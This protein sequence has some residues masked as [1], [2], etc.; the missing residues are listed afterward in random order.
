MR[1]FTRSTA[2]EGGASVDNAS[3]EKG[4][5]IFSKTGILAP[6]RKT[7]TSAT[8]VTRTIKASTQQL[9]RRYVLELIFQEKEL[10]PSKDGR[11]IP[12]GPH[13]DKPLIDERRGSAYI[14][15]TIRTSRYTIYDFIPKQLFF[16][17]SRLA[18]FYFLCVGVPQTIPGVSTTGNFTTI[19]PLLFFVFLTVVK[20]GYDDWKRH[21]L[22]KVENARSATVLRPTGHVDSRQDWRTGF[23]LRRTKDNKTVAVEEII[24][25]SEY[26]WHATQWK[27]LKVGDV[28][29]LSRDEDVP[30]D[31][32]LLYADGENSMAYIETMSLDGETNLKNKQVSKALQRCNTIQGIANCQAEFVVEDPNPDLYRFDGRVT[33]DG[34]TLPLTLNEV[35][36]R[37]CT[38]RNTTCAIGM[39]I[40]TGEECKLRR[41]ADRHPKAKKPA[42]EKIANRIVISLVVV[43]ISLS[44]GCSMGYLIWKNA[45]EHK[46]WY[47]RHLGVDFEDII[48]GFFIQFNNIIPLA[49]YVSLEIVKLGQMWFLNSDVEMYDKV[50]DTPAKCN[51]NTILENLGQIGYVFSDKTGTLTENVMKFR[52]MSIAGTTWLHEMDIVKEQEEQGL[53]QTKTKGKELNVMLE[54]TF[55]NDN[56]L[57]KTTTAVSVRS[58]NPRRSSSQWRSTGR[59][60]HVQPEVTT[61][62]LLEYIRLRPKAPFSRKAIQYL[63]AMALCHTCLPEIRDGE[64][65]FQAASPDELA[66][67]KAAQELGF[68]VVQRSSQSVTLRISRGDGTEL[69]RTYQILDLIEFSSKRKRM[70]II[71]RCPDERIWLIT[72]GADSVILPRLRMAQLAIQKA[73]EVRKSLEVEHEMQRRSEAR[74]PRNSFGGRPSLTIRRSIN[75]ARQSSVAGPSKRP[76]T[77]RSKSFEVGRMSLSA[78]EYHLRPQVTVRT[79]SYDVPYE[80]VVAASVS[81]KFA[82]LDDPSVCDEGAIFTRCFK[83]IDDFAT[84][85]LRTLL[86]A[87]RFLS[88]S[89]YNT[90]KKLYRDAETSL[91]DR[92]ERIETA[93]ELIEQTLDLIGATAI[94]DKLQKGVPETIERLRRANIKIWML[95][96]DKRETAINIAH[97]ARLC[98]PTSDIYILDATKGN[99]EGQIMDIVDELNIRAETMPTAIPNHTVVV[100]DGHTLAALDE[101]EA[102]G[103]A[104]ELFY[105]LIPTI[106]SVICCRA[107]PAQKAL[108]VTAIR[109]H[110][111]QPST[112]KKKGFLAYLVTPKRTP[113]LTLA[114]GDGANDLAMLSA[115]HVGVGIS[116]REGLQ[117]ARVADYAVSQFRFLSRLLLVHGRWNY[118]RTSKFIVATFWKEMFFYLPTELYQR[119][120]GYTG[121][122]LY[123]S[124]SLTVLNTLFTSLCVIVPGVWEQDLSAETLMAVPEL[125]VWGQRDG[126][127]N[128]RKYL[129]WMVAA[130]AQGVVV[131]W[132]CWGL[133][134][135]IAVKDN[136][137]FAVGNLVFTVA[138]VWT[139]LKLIIIDTHHKT[140]I[141]L[142]AFGITFAGWWIWQIFLASAYAPGV[143]PYAV[144][145]GFFSSFGPDPAWWVALFAAVGLL[146][147]VELGYKSTKRNLIIS[148]LWRLGWRKWMQWETWKGLLALGRGGGARGA[149]PM[150]AWDEA[151]GEGRNVDEWDVELWQALERE[152]TVRE[153]LKGMARVGHEGDGPEPEEKSKEEE[154]NEKNRV[155]GSSTMDSEGQHES[156]VVESLQISK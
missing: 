142:G 67:V 50:S 121:T 20:E 106:D 59:P 60:D 113:P 84:E 13:H 10:P 136:G 30:A 94:E 79:A 8:T 72:K 145:G 127:L 42:M 14:P 102:H 130:V 15:N 115:A 63:L 111:H 150:W 25:D 38:L 6:L 26:Q 23:G 76:I 52:K 126:G 56:A 40:N 33:V 43:V 137:L 3:F 143:W 144:R 74:E 48:I 147:A 55:E 123:E 61:E 47:L 122:S 45:Y 116:G 86:F 98:R 134:G 62:D 104:K 78:P 16:Q 39:V 114:I 65:E 32:V 69:E 5:S 17:F 21:R 95:T 28:I 152:Q 18:N 22:D 119:Y 153:A 109:N 85:G 99:L 105:S 51:T 19:I 11:H 24:P 139:N 27:D 82:F 120:T 135:G 77:N 71:V 140:G 49:L 138:I 110:S 2:D 29:K 124:W 36:Y 4:L 133:Y 151:G 107:S 97:S 46:A 81:D 101:P 155:E 75:L 12:L 117:A 132:V 64:I 70:S 57:T 44:V 129:G 156:A 131:W 66:L 103:N 34:E 54:P 118:A 9:Y 149:G 108:L 35:V 125:Y 73:N 7:R 96:G 80:D 88:E 112:N 91:V 89:E 146:T 83:H 31:I 87:Q 1:S 90:W 141:I 41:N 154:E 58:P 92:Q 148:G 100:I 128:L 68:L 93:G 53:T 37:G